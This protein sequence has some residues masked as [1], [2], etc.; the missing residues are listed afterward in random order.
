MKGML[1]MSMEYIVKNIEA[2]DN[3]RCILYLSLRKKA[4]ISKIIPV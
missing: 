3:S 1:K 4:Y 2:I